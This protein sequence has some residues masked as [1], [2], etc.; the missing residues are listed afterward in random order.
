MIDE[1]LRPLDVCE[2]H[3]LA[4]RRGIIRAVFI[5]FAMVATISMSTFAQDKPAGKC[6]PQTHKD[7]VVETIHGVSVSDPYRWLEDQ[8]GPGRARGLRLRTSARPRFS[9]L[10]Q[11]A[12]RFRSGFR[13]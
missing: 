4:T 10:C 2:G 5:L 3:S 9:K 8:K 7:D 13:N 12:Q 6:P 11:A 1:D